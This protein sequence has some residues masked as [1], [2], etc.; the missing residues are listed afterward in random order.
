MTGF[1]TPID[2]G[3]RACDHAGQTLLDATL[4]FTDT[5]KKHAIRIGSVY[6]KLRLVELERNFW[7]FAVRRVVL[8]VID[9]DTMVLTPS[10]W[11]ST[12][13]YFVGSIIQDDQG[14]FWISRIPNNLGNQPQ[15]APVAWEPYFGSKT[16][17]LYDATLT[18]SAGE[19][20]YT[21][22]GDGTNRVYL[23]LQNANS[24]NPATA[25]AWDATV[26]YRKNDVVTYSAVAYMS[27]TDLNINNT[28]TASPAGWASATTY[29]L[30]D[31]VTGSDTIVYKSLA[32]GNIGNDP[33]SDAGVHWQSQG[34]YGH[35]TSTFTGGSGSIKWRQ[36]GGA[37]FPDGVTLSELNITYP[38][39]AGPSSQ[40]TTANVFMLP[41][42]YLRKAPQDPKAGAVSGLGIPGY[43]VYDDWIIESGFI[44]SRES[45]PILFRFVA[46]FTDVSR[47]HPMF[48]EGLGAR[49]GLAIIEPVTQSLG[50]RQAAAGEYQRFMS[51]ARLVNAIENDATE[52]PLDDFI[53]CRA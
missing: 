49:I 25:T 22:A 50:K 42:G 7:T 5:S 17:P 51:E 16:V 12:T 11:V 53:A 37:E 9:T 1:L 45:G 24:D 20:V 23:S 26:T 39:G 46:D 33:V 40:S 34:I 48:C 36:I 15:N 4:G 35:W 28:P 19:I 30:D 14:R 32:G 10:L 31:L 43:R 3:N 47:M 52:S 29:A 8:R 18:Y 6:D 41:A 44:I 27:L 21:A 2:I 38:L 13:T